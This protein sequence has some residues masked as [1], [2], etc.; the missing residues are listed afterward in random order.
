[1]AGY[2]EELTK[3]YL[4]ELQERASRISE[5]VSS[6]VGK[7]ADKHAMEVM[8]PVAKKEVSTLYIDAANEW[9]NAYQVDIGEPKK[10]KRQHSLRNA[11]IIADSGDGGFGWVVEEE[12]MKPSWSGGAYNIYNYIFEKGSHGGPVNGH[13]P[14]YST[15]IPELFGLFDESSDQYQETYKMLQGMFDESGQEYFDANF[16]YEF[17]KYFS[18]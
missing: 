13:P 10:Y 18:L 15:S 4:A 12:M 9:Y 17:Q 3:K 14:K 16:P 5:E 6:S 2:I 11:L 7:E 1:M 8:I